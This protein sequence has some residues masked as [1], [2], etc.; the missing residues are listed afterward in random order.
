MS[1]YSRGTFGKDSFQWTKCVV[2]YVLDVYATAS[3]SM[4]SFL[5]EVLEKGPN[6]YQSS[7]FQI[8]HCMVHYID[9]SSPSSSV[10]N[11]ELIHV[12]SK[13][14]EGSH[15]K[16]ALKIL[17]LAVTRSSTLAAAPLSTTTTATHN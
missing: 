9:I 11:S 15:H 3:L 5:V 2:K 17:K 13:H 7:V 8:L 12:I 10:L 4:I 16:E 6:S 14:V 1:L